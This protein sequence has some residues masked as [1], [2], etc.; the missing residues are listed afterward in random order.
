MLKVALKARFDESQHKFQV[1]I[2][3]MAVKKEF[4]TLDSKKACTP[5]NNGFNYTCT[6]VNHKHK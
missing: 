6:N 4:M 1:H 2:M 5:S 3:S